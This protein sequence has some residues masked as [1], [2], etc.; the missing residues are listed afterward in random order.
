MTSA[1]F[2]KE[3]L[4]LLVSA[5]LETRRKSL[6]RLERRRGIQTQTK[7]QNEK[8]DSHQAPKTG[9]PY[10]PRKVWEGDWKDLNVCLFFKILK[11]T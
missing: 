9:S 5:E 4:L 1:L 8:K 6:A 11:Q 10:K 7:Y 2:K 3:L